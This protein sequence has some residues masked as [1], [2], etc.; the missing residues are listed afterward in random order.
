MLLVG[1]DHFDIETRSDGRFGP[2]VMEVLSQAAEVG[3]WSSTLT[4]ISPDGRVDIADLGPSVPAPRSV[5]AVGLNY[6]SHAVESGQAI[7]EAPMIF[8]KF[9]SCLVGP[10]DP[11]VL[12]SDHVDYEVELVVV[13]GKSGRNIAESEA[14]EHILGITV[15]QDVSDRQL[16]M[17]G[18]QPQFSLGK[19][20]D[21]FGPL[22]PAVVTLDEIGDINDLEIWCEVDGREVQRANTSD[23]V[24]S[25]QDLLVYVSSFVTLHPGDLIF[26]GTPAGVGLGFDPPRYLKPGSTIRSG[27]DGVGVMSNLCVEGQLATTPA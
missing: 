4:D 7:P 20:L 1:D 5:F 9:P 14:E 11:V 8:T 13:V 22:G 24:F 25:P 16:Q 23:L 19:S 18:A 12:S 3:R 10:G 26:T 2:D 6:H 17:Q 27:I 21:S 15:G